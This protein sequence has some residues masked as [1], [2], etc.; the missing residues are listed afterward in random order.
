MQV[1][2][3]ETYGFLILKLLFSVPFIHISDRSDAY[4]EHEI[5]TK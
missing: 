5:I 2:L 1:I 3:C 4:T